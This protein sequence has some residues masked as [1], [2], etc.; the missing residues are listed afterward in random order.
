MALGEVY[1]LLLRLLRGLDQL[2][3]P[4]SPTGLAR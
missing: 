1:D 2:E 4:G 3:I